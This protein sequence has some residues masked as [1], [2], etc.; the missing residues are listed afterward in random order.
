MNNTPTPTTLEELLDRV[1][2]ATART[3]EIVFTSRVWIRELKRHPQYFHR[4]NDGE[5]LYTGYKVVMLGDDHGF[6]AMADEMI[7]KENI[8]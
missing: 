1:Q 2:T 5:L 6:W 4:S 7:K 8:K 3:P